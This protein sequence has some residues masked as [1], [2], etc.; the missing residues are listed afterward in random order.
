[1]MVIRKS[2]AS[3]IRSVLAPP[4]V[5]LDTAGIMPDFGENFWAHEG[6]C[7]PRAGF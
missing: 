6:P 4:V 3:S 5:N 2:K 1:M 7:Q